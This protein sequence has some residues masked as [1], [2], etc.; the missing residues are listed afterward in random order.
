MN[1]PHISIEFTFR[2]KKKKNRDFELRVRDQ[3]TLMAFATSVSSNFSLSDPV[4]DIVTLDMSDDH[5]KPALSEE[6]FTLE[7][8]GSLKVQ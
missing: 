5:A 8:E 6:I 1:G 7:K 3:N 2:I 4:S